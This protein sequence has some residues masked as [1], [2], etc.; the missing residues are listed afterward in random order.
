MKNKIDIVVTW[1]DG[2][3]KEWQKEKA[4]YS[5]VK[6]TDDNVNR[7]RDWGILKYWFRA[8]AQYAPWVNKVH[9]ITWGHLPE[10][11]NVDCE[12]LNI[13]EHKDYIPQ[14]YLP[15][16]SSH[17]IEH[18][19]FRIEGLAEQFIY[20]N[21]DMFMISPT[22]PKDYFKDG[23]PVDNVREVPLRF[24]EGGV[25]HIIANNMIVINKYF[26]KRQVVKKCA[27]QWFSLSSPESTLKNLYMLPVNGFSA[28]D[29]P[30]IPIPFLKS[31][32]QEVW[33]KEYAK[34]DDT[35]SHRFRSSED[36]NPWLY[37][38]WQFVTGK[39]VQSKK[40]QGMFFVIGKDDDLIEDALLNHKYKMVCLSDD[41]VDIDYEKEQKFLDTLFSKILPHKSIFEK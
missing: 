20:F 19:M 24:F 26:N 31:T 38:Y 30:H 37:R 10:W 27:K 33:D 17:P 25:D 39:F 32:L 3:D 13:V 14:K 18:N 5:G 23:L 6:Y 29:N 22:V 15:V 34:L 35:C 41:V 1:V 11:L 8:I 2:S 21:D 9:F 12:K 7:Y 28:F 40:P 16:F 4:K 36:V